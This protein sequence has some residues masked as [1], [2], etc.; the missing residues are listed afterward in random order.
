M[1]ITQ[2]VSRP[3]VLER[4]RQE[5]QLTQPERQQ[6]GPQEVRTA[7]W[8]P[9]LL[10]GAPAPWGPGSQ[11]QSLTG[12]SAD[13]G[14]SPGLTTRF[15]CLNVCSCSAP[16]LLS[17]TGTVGP[18][19]RDRVELARAAP[20]LSVQAQH[21]DSPRTLAAGLAMTVLEKRL[22]CSLALISEL[23]IPGLLEESWRPGPSGRACGGCHPLR[24]RLLPGPWGWCARP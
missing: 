10:G 7:M 13:L 9:G 1:R 16:W 19:R 17:R 14:L 5:P 11:A 12:Q 20:R 3:R 8:G 22:V 2:P 24:V 6:V 15:C 4:T 21:A 18:T 23:G